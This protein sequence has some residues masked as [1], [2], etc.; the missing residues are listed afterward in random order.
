MHVSLCRKTKE[1]NRI[2]KTKVG[3]A[4]RVAGVREVPP[5]SMFAGFPS[6]VIMF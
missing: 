2:R 6:Q 5:Q 4:V 1:I 3:G